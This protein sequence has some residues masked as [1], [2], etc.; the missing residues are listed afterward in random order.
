VVE[1]TLEGKDNQ[2]KEYTIGTEVLNKPHGFNPQTDASVRINA[3][4]L[5]K[6]LAEYYQQ[7]NGDTQIRIELPKGSYKPSFLPFSKIDEIKSPAHE[8][9]NAEFGDIV[10]IL[11]FSGFTHQTSLDF[12]ISG[13]C[14]FLSQKLSLFQDIKVVSFHSASRYMQEDGRME[15]IASSLGLSYYLSGSIEP[16]NNKLQVSYQLVEAKSNLI[17]WSQ[18]TETSLLSTSLEKATDTISSQIVA[19]HKFNGKIGK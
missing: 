13:F 4:R 5:R 7:K 12:S 3:V 19:S 18:Q 1:E 2:I 17:I 11:A 10:G 6:M 9:E 8:Q 14:K 15:H 16:G